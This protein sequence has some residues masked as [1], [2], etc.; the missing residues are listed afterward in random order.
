MAP[1]NAYTLNTR[2][3]IPDIDQKLHRA[4]PASRVLLPARSRSNYWS[5]APIPALEMTS[6]IT[7]KRLILFDIDLDELDYHLAHPSFEV[8][9]PRCVTLQC[10]PLSQGLKGTSTTYAFK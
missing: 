3:Q 1:E 6:K 2:Y 9:A 8:V 5:G 10:P 4:F 7:G